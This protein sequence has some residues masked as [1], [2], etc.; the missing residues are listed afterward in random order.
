MEQHACTMKHLF[1][2]ELQYSDRAIECMPVGMKEGRIIG[3]GEGTV[4]GSKINGRIRWSNYEN[5]VRQ[6]LCKLQIPGKVTTHDGAILEFEA[7]GMAMNPDRS[8]PSK[9]LVSGVLYF[10]TNNGENDRYDW[11]S[12][13]LAFYE[14]EFDMETARALYHVYSH[15]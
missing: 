15:I 14:G 10:Q 1:D 5:T 11:L 6:G 8:Q 9:W 13:I 2:M 12:N 3:S 7:R 4:K